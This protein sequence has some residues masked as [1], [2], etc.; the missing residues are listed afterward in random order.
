MFVNNQCCN[1]RHATVK[2]YFCSPDINNCQHCQSFCPYYLPRQF[3]C[4]IFVA[5]YIPPSAVADLTCKVINS[6]TARLQ[7]QHPNAFI[8]TSGHFNHTFLSV[9]LSTFQ[10]FASCPTR[11]NK[12]ME[13][14]YAN[15]KDAQNSTALSPL[16]RSVN[17]LVFLDPP[18]T[19][20]LRQQPATTRTVR[21]WLWEPF[22]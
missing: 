15:V 3:T 16:G 12:T 4:A 2:K 6:I 13:L 1:P 22:V 7:T 11:V 20:I 19:P 18:Y 14:L 21:W 10:Q 8:A 9:T 17:N 5:V